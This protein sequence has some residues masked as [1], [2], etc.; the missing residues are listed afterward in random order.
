ML[1]VSNCWLLTSFLFYSLQ[2]TTSSSGFQD[3]E[4]SCTWFYFFILLFITIA[5]KGLKVNHVKLQVLIRKFIE[6][7]DKYMA[8]VNNCFMNHTLF[9][10]VCWGNEHFIKL[11]PLD[12]IL[13]NRAV[14]SIFFFGPSLTMVQLVAQIN[15]PQIGTHLGK[16]V[17]GRKVGYKNCKKGIIYWGGWPGKEGE[18]LIWSQWLDLSLKIEIFFFFYIASL[19][20]FVNT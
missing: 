3:Q 1:I 16:N 20:F 17:E 8:Y 4:S 19:F 5:I 12:N 6:L 15:V 2:K 9:H 18:G 10:K 14:C 13:N 7:H 11:F